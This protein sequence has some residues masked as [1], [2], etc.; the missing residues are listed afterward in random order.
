MKHYVHDMKRNLKYKKM[1]H[2][3]YNMK[4]NLKYKNRLVEA[5]DKLTYD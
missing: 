1:K 4:R 2:N 3:V 5:K